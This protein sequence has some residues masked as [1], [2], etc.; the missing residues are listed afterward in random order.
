MLEISLKLK[1]TNVMEISIHPI[2]S[3]EYLADENVWSVQ[4]SIQFK[5]IIRQDGFIS[6]YFQLPAYSWLVI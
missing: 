3:E 6:L 4:K 1:Y 5:T 2:Q